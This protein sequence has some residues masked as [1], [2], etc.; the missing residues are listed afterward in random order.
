[1]NTDIRYVCKGEDIEMEQLETFSLFKGLS[2][3]KVIEL[4]HLLEHYESDVFFEK[5]Q[6]AANGKSV[7]GMMSVF[8]TVRIGDKIHMRVKGDDA[9]SMRSAVGHF[10]QNSQTEDETLGYWEQEGI[11]TVEKAMTAS[12]NSWTPDVRNVAKSYLKTTRQ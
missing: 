10:L 12:L 4:V 11:E 3:Q 6:A 1:M 8:T 5:K 2:V 9:D 7:L